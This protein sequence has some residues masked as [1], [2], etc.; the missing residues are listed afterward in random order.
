[1]HYAACPHSLDAFA[2]D[3]LASFEPNL[4]HRRFSRAQHL[5]ELASDLDWISEVPVGVQ[6]P[7]SD[8]LGSQFIEPCPNFL[9]GAQ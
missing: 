5:T 2:S 7:L 8:V 3:R 6:H 1:M 4:L 9:C